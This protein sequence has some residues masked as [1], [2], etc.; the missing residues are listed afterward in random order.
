MCPG[1]IPGSTSDIECFTEVINY[2]LPQAVADIVDTTIITIPSED[3]DK[4]RHA[5]STID[6]DSYD[7]IITLGLRFYSKISLETTEIL[8]K[9]FTGILCQT[10]DGTRLDHDPVD[11]TFTFKD[12]TA[13]MSTNARWYNRHVNKNVCMGWAADPELNTPQQS[14]TDLRILVDHTNY[15]DNEI[16]LTAEV[17]NQIKQFVESNL[18]TSRYQSV[19]VRRFDSGK[20]VDVNLNDLNYNRY[21]RTKTIPLT[22]VSKEHSATHIFCVTHPE[23]VGLVVLETALAGAYIVSPRG[24][25]SPDRLETVRHIEWEETIDWNSVLDS[26]NIVASRKKALENTWSKV[27]TNIVNCLEKRINL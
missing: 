13:R 14:V 27:A 8:Q 20:I 2:Y 6:V 11:I 19:S 5:F 18:W 26:I 21:D 12:D 7:A 10:H 17:L 22:E 16:D 24:F 15:G 25:I 1:K 9:R 23:S 4:L 3:G